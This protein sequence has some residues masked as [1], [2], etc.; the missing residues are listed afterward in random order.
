MGCNSSTLAKSIQ[1]VNDGKKVVQQKHQ[2]TTAARE[3]V[4]IT[5][6]ETG[7]ESLP[8]SKGKIH[9]ST[10]RKALGSIRDYMLSL[11]K[12]PNV[13]ARFLKENIILTDTT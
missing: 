1:A 12:V 13:F 5:T 11:M 3:N 9:Y 4:L 10:I 6:N 2:V 7:N 8:R